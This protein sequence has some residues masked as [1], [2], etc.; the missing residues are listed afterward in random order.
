MSDL[1]TPVPVRKP[2]A[3]TRI[4]IN[5]PVIPAVPN[6]ETTEITNIQPSGMTTESL[7]TLPGL[8][9]QLSDS[10]L[11]SKS[12]DELKELC[13]SRGIKTKASTVAGLVKAYKGLAS[14][15]GSVAGS[16]RATRA[17]RPDRGVSESGDGKKKQTARRQTTKQLNISD[18]EVT[19]Y[20]T[21]NNHSTTKEELRDR[22]HQ[23]HN[24]LR[25]KG[26]GY[27]FNGL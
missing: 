2:R 1:I 25:N 26:I 11:K 3:S 21:G 22:V 14:T 13:K 4:T 18:T 24:L 16:D 8:A 5:K 19:E 12:V 23:I 17:A 15:V 27:G 6:Q 20:T 10:E 7:T 9:M